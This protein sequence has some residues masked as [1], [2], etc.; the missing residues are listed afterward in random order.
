MNSFIDQPWYQFGKDFI[1]AALSVWGLVIA[2]KGLVTWRKQIRGTKEFDA[3]YN[4]HYALLKLRTSIR[5]V[6]SPVIW[7]SESYKAI[8]YSRAK[9][10]HKTEAEIE[11]NSQPYVYEMRWEEISNALTEVESHLLAA[12]VL[13]GKEILSLMQRVV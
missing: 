11:K 13:W 10:P 7:P 8:Q 1:T 3:G 12:E 2:T 5:H 6:R 4:L 9:Y